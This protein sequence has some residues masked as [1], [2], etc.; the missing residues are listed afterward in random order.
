MRLSISNIAWEE[1]NDKLVY[2]LM[3]KYGFLGVEIAPTRWVQELPYEH[4]DEATRIAMEV[5]DTYGFEVS[6][7]QSIWFG[8]QE[9][10]FASEEER[11][12]LVA[13]TKKAI[14]YASAIGCKNLVFGCPRNRSVSEEYQLNE[15]QVA[16]IAIAFF[17]EIGDYA[18]SK[19]TVIGMEANP[20][21]YNTNYINTTEEAL[22]LIEKV[23]SKGFLLNLDIGTM[24]FNEEDVE[25][26]NGKVAFINHVHVSEPGLKLIEVRE[27]HQKIRER[28]QKEGYSGYVS[29]EV[30]KQDDMQSLSDVMK[31]VAEV[32]HD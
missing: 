25:V 31:Y 19:G 32:F 17:K 4:V 22:A 11:D 23:N 5:K 14:D 15:Q 27:L 20:T 21:I 2:E 30:G 24:V 9:K 8:K 18:Y 26:L 13:Y 12:E 29:I 3:E 6:S 1:K 10:L 28:L 16:E 7:M